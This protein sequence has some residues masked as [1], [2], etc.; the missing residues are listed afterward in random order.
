MSRK[1]PVPPEVLAACLIAARVQFPSNHSISFSRD[2]Y[3]QLFY[4][5]SKAKTI[6][7]HISL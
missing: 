5:A 3:H 1:I 4:T 6:D 2:N 7:M